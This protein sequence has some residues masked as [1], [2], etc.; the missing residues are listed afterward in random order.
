MSK[1]PTVVVLS[2]GGTI[3]MSSGDS[4]RKGGVRPA[5]DAAALVAAVPDVD[6]VADVRAQAVRSVPGASLRFDDLLGV[7]TNARSEVD[8]G[9]AGIVV[10]Q[11]TDTIEES[12]YFLDLLWDRPEPLVVTGAMRHPEQPGADG[13]ANLLAAVVVAASAPARERGVLVVL[14]DEIHAARHVRK[15]HSSALGAFTSPDTG[16]TGRV[17]EGSADFF[18]P[19]PAGR[20]RLPVPTGRGWP[21]VALVEAVLDEAGG[22]LPLISEDTYDAVVISAFGVGHVSRAMAERIGKLTA[23]MPVAFASRT[24]AGGTFARTYGFPG[25]EADLLARGAIPAGHLDPRKARILLTVLLAH[26]ANLDEIRAAFDVHGGAGRWR[27]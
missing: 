26:G 13:P 24:G 10:T 15:A 23:S 27:P 17:R 21:R 14:N 9:A 11:G 3:A 18:A 25:S 4:D 6:T 20:E 2:L 19:A 16:P 8:A 5:L 22:L 7:L 12:A 1:L